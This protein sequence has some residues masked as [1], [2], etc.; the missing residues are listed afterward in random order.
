VQSDHKVEIAKVEA[1]NR[2][3]KVLQAVE[4]VTAAE[5]LVATSVL[6]SNLQNY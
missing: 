5:Q 3:D 1:D 2:A 6:S 4:L